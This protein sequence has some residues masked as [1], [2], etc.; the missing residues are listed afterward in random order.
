MSKIISLEMSDVK[1]IKAV[2][3]EPKDNGL[4]IIGGRNF[5]HSRWK[6]RERGKAEN[7]Q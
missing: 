4:T 2:T 7:L 1:R 3:L 5:F 6:N